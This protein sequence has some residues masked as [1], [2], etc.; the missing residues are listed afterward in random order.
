[1]NFAIA[2]VPQFPGNQPSNYANYWGFAVA[3]NKKPAEGMTDE[4]RIAEDWKFIDFLTTKPEGQFVSSSGM[5]GGGSIDPSYDPAKLYLEKTRKPAARRD[6]IELQKTDPEL[7]V[8]AKDNL[9]AKSWKQIQPEAIENI[10][11]EMID[12]VNRGQANIND[13]IETASQRI[14]ELYN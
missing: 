8:F 7:G 11:A 14:L 6:L 9:I 3:R 2:S 4:G 12:Q 1:L 10:F 5:L 13:A